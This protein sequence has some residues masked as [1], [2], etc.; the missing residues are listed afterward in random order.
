MGSSFPS[1]VSNPVLEAGE[2]PM[3]DGGSGGTCG[4][5]P[6]SSSCSRA[7]RFSLR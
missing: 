6:L 1:P 3:A 5:S 7:L 2:K 4:S